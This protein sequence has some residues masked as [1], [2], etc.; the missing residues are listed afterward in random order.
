MSSSSLPR[1]L[2]VQAETNGST[3]SQKRS[4]SAQFAVAGRGEVDSTRIRLATPKIVLIRKASLLSEDRRWVSGEIRQLSSFVASTHGSSGT[5]HGSSGTHLG[6]SGTHLLTA[7]SEPAGNRTP[8]LPPGAAVEPVQ[9][10]EPTARLIDG[11]SN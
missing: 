7:S 3:S 4:P 10:L 11:Q 8:N 5:H 1:S 6:S 2:L 9:A